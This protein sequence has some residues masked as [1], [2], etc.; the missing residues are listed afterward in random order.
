MRIAYTLP[1]AICCIKNPGPAG[2]NRQALL[3]CRWMRN[4]T[5]NS[6]IPNMLALSI[7]YNCDISISGNLATQAMTNASLRPF[8]TWLFSTDLRLIVR[9]APTSLS[10]NFCR[11]RFLGKIQLLYDQRNRLKSNPIG[12]CLTPSLCG[13]ERAMR[14]RPAQ[15]LVS[16]QLEEH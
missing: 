13:A 15:R 2:L 5:S 9:A 7:D 10:P 8:S 14:E 11:I 12:K 3:K 16:E 1:E 6:N 4:K